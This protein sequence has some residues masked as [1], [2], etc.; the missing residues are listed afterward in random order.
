MGL[1]E[2]ILVI[3]IAGIII[4]LILLKLVF[5][6][7]PPP[8]PPPIVVTGPKPTVSAGTVPPMSKWTIT[9]DPFP[10]TVTSSG[11]AVKITA[12]RKGSPITGAHVEA[13]INEGVDPGISSLIELHASGVTVTGTGL[14]GFTDAYGGIQFTVKATAQGED[15]IT[16]TVDPSGKNV[17]TSSDYE[18]IA[19]P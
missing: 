14:K 10:N 12:F 7:T 1:T 9:P 11:V 18:T 13:Q 6:P 17:T 4:Y 19:P 2:V 3:V 16:I 8:P 5:K 15:N